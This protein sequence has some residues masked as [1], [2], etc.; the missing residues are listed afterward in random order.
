M[1]LTGYIV[2]SLLLALAYAGV[3]GIYLHSWRRLPEWTVPDRY[4]PLTT[5]TVLVPARNEAA[6]L[7]ACLDSILSASYPKHLLELIVL[8]DHSEDDTARIA[9]R[10]QDRVRLIRLAEVPGEVL[11]GKK[12]AI[13]KGVSLARGEL[14]VTTDADCVVPPDW[15]RLLVSLYEARRP[16]AIAAPVLFRPGR[17][18]FQAFQAL[19]NIGMMG[20]TA[21][22]IGLDWHRMGNGA[23]LCYP[24]TVFESVGGYSGLPDRASGDDLFILQKIARRASVVFLK[25]P[26]AAVQTEACPDLS[27]FV[28][29]RLRW[30]TKNAALPE[31]TV[32]A[33]LALVFF[34]CCSVVTNFLLVFYYPPLVWMLA[35]QLALK[36][37]A[38]FLFLSEL[39]AFF[40]RR[41]LMHWFWPAF[42]LHIAYI[43][44]MGL[45]SLF[46]PRYT[47]KG[48]LL[49]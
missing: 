16:G 43:A 15:L 31:K 42:L 12:K 47:W 9:S 37:L 48:R 44:G 1:I 25:N 22:G 45:L 27:A 14:I 20:I 4:V 33:V 7:A 30:G 28:Q 35:I 6:M 3:M 18:L 40:R 11:A 38:D 10:Y 32:K 17:S 23:S 5:V 2:L 46:L 36:A 34:L 41:A 13:E 49:R 21:A 26:E 19:D 29:Q 24:K 39:C 8:D